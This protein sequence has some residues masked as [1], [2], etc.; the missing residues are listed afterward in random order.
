MGEA[1]PAP[2]TVPVV[3]L[4]PFTSGSDDPKKR[5]DAAKAFTSVCQSHG[6]VQ[7]VGHGIPEELVHEAFAWSKKLYDL[8]HEEKMKAPHPA[9]P[10]PHRGYSH[11]GL[12][13]VM[14]QRDIPGVDENENSFRKVQDFKVRT[15]SPLLC[16]LGTITP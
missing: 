1:S 9:G 16:P 10:M 5:Q 13:K 6:F 8:P 15:T 4:S 14:H 11:P 7:V 3:D 12:E 2:F